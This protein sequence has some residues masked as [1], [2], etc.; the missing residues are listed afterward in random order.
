MRTAV[1]V[2]LALVAAL[3]GGM[4][5]GQEIPVAD[6]PGAGGLVYSVYDPLYG[7]PLP[8]VKRNQ[9]GHGHPLTLR[10]KQ[11]ARG[12]GCCRYSI[13]ELEVP[14]EARALRCIIGIDDEK[15][16]P[17]GDTYFSVWAEG[18]RLWQSPALSAEDPPLWINVPVCGHRRIKLITDAQGYE[19]YDLADWCDVRWVTAAPPGE[20]SWRYQLEPAAWSVRPELHPYHLAYRREGLP[21][22]VMAGS[23]APAEATC[24][25]RDERE[26]VVLDKRLPLAFGHSDIGPVPARVTIP[27]AGLKLGLYVARLGVMSG[28]G[29]RSEREVRFGLMEP[30]VGEPPSGTIYG[31]NHHEFAA[32]Y[33]PLRAAGIEW[34]RQWF[35]WAWIQ[36]R[37]GEWHWG[38]HDERIAAAAQAGVKTIG[39]LGGI[40]SP[41]WSSPTNVALGQPTTLGCPEDMG[42]WEEYV[43]Q[44][45]TRYKGRLSVW[46]SWNEIM[47][48][49]EA[50]LQGWS[51]AKYIELHRRT[52]RVLK[53]VD[54]QNKLLL[55]ADSLG[56][57]QACLQAGLGECFDGIVPHPYRG[58]ASPEAGVSN[59]CVGNLGDVGSVF[60][61]GR[62]W[63]DDHGR[64]KA[65]IW[66][67]EIGW[68]LTGGDGWATV[69]VET[70]GEYLPRAYLLAQA[71]D[72]CANLSWHDFG[73][74]MFG[75]FDGQGFPRPAYL[76]YAGL[77]AR[78]EGARPLKRWRFRAPLHAALFARGGVNVLALWA[79]SGVEFAMLRPTRDL[80]L[81][82]YDW[83]G[84]PT[85]LDLPSS[86]Q[87]V[88]ATGRVMYLEGPS[89]ADL[90]ITPVHPAQVAAVPPSVV[91]GH[92][93]GISCTVENLVGGAGEFALQVEPPAGL[94]AERPA[95]TL[96]VPP[97]QS[98]AA[99]FALTADRGAPCGERRV[100]VTVTFPGGFSAP[101]E[102]YLT[103]VSPFSLTVE[104]FDCVALVRGPVAAKALVRNDDDRP[105]SG[106]V[107]FLAPEG[108]GVSPRERS[109]SNLA[110]G[111]TVALPVALS[112]T[113]APRPGEDLTLRGAAD[114]ATV[115]IARSLTPVIRD[116][117]H[118]GL[119]TGWH[120]N[121]QGPPE[122]P[123]RA[124]ASIEEGHAEFL[125]QKITCTDFGGGWVI[126]HRDGQDHITKGKRYRVSFWARQRGLKGTL[127]V[128]VYN[129]A[130]WESCGLES[131]FR[132]GGDWQKITTEF[133][134]AR[135]SDN[136]RFEFFLTETGTVWIEGMRLE[137]AG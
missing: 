36:P 135:D 90:D 15:A 17:S 99:I 35:C 66:A 95:L 129:I 113:R 94:R 69:P 29:L 20:A 116:E 79:E 41:N 108:F 136:V 91:A 134:A 110:P 5:S 137:P 97:G 1:H 103:I 78:L 114:G 54:P 75:F 46:E 27:L 133:T 24:V 123:D 50:K 55:S 52:W 128:A 23:P 47:G 107:S 45:A 89:L 62:K 80:R 109:F 8:E 57:V 51:V 76:S 26:A 72:H 118:N 10:G 59:Y 28:G 44:V 22:S 121:P 64:P 88:P 124:T 84:N 53:E 37:R 68:A 25:V 39:V 16:G 130:P 102:A 132:V 81:T 14:S 42:A 112:G 9:N 98:R 33:E 83:F 31:V 85:P 30:R 93:A 38:W 18:K 60:D 92:S 58:I 105:L 71:S 7:R 34:S 86:G 67:T 65:Q 77:I 74:G 56:F 43:R 21:V 32:S 11:F 73:L 127:S 4:A 131:G 70:H 104:P 120:L 115:E 13:I 48:A 12:F 49:A 111:A 3:W 119:A 19:N 63:L 2:M 40:G 6:G 82:A 122:H 101:L 87:A 106:T 117:D 61:A 125:C 96:S 126:L 100:P